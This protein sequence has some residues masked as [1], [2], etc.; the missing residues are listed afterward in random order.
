[1]TT[2]LRVADHFSFP[3]EL[4]VHQTGILARTGAGKTNTAVVIAEEV[5]AAR[6]Q[7][8]ILDPPGAWWGLRSSADGKAPGYEI[9]V[10]GGDH[11]DLPLEAG[12]G[13]TI[14]DFVVDERASVILD[15]SEFS[16]REMTTFVTAFAERL[17]RRKA[18]Q[19]DPMLLIVEEADEV[20]P[21]QPMPEQRRMLGSIER[22]VKRGRMRG[23]GS[24]LITQR[25]AS[26]NKNVLSQIGTLIAMQTTAPQDIKTIDDW[27]K[28]TGDQERR[29][30][31]LGGIAELPI[32]TAF[33]WSPAWL[34]IFECVHFR[35]R[36][37]FD[38]SATPR[39][40]ESRVAPKTL[41]DVDLEA[42]RE[43]MAATIERA[44]ADDP[45]EL[46]KRIAE[47]ERQLRQRPTET[48]VET[49]VERVE[50]PVLTE[51][52]QGSLA[53]L[54]SRFGELNSE[55]VSAVEALTEKLVDVTPN[56]ERTAGGTAYIRSE[57]PK[58]RPDPIPIRKNAAPAEQSSSAG[59]GDLSAYARRL[60]ET[61][62]RYYPRSLTRSQ[63]A[64]LSGYSIRSSSF[65]AHVS[66]L[67]SDGLIAAAGNDLEITEAGFAALGQ[68]APREPQS[69]E[70]LRDMWLQAL[71]PAERAMLGALLDHY[72]E[73][74]SRE[75][76]SAETGYSLTS[77]S[78]SAALS[79]LRRHELIEDRGDRQVRASDTLFLG[80]PS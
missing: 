15:L 80:A 51:E 45:Q 31:L 2:D 33:V 23:I 35:R 63:L 57:T 30:Q 20:A 7:C 39:P 74:L 60:L 77:S 69:P 50:V 78:F 37:T 29:R 22:I 25:S 28:D 36:R 47:L 44:K 6:Q 55:L 26:L 71:R 3:L 79:V 13:Q 12:A 21:Q 72:P 9:V 34:R 8:V 16:N 17:Y 42:L 75:E 64:T 14:A 41:A 76:L 5:L 18:T 48:V 70:E 11:G 65:T 27:V 4:V 68:D 1:V 56:V 40:G 66:Q 43:R 67:R 58:P 61:F 46:R 24:L 62:A 32:G 10:L 52:D 54:A 59:N 38:S 53:L 19:R 73:P 49:R